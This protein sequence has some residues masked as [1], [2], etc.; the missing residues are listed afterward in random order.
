MT[1][2][3]YAAAHERL[4][5]DLKKRKRKEKKSKTETSYLHSFSITDCLQIER[6][7]QGLLFGCVGGRI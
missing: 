4:F 1:T 5:S 6:I 2:L 3:D 7:R